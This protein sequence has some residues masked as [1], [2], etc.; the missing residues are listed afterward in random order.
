M[1]AAE[2]MSTEKRARL[3]AS[4]E[5]RI[6]SKARRRVYSRVG[7]MWHFAVFAMVNMA[8]TAI[9]FNYTPEYLWFVWPLAGWGSGLM[10]HAFA[11][12]MVGGMTEEM[13]RLEIE[14]EKQRRGLID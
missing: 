12:F 6:R 11:T 4:I 9:N 1:S 13:V 5:R 7:F 3:E 2:T 10:L 14:R 8:L